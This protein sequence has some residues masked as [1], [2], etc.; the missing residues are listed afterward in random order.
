MLL[1]YSTIMSNQLLMITTNTIPYTDIRGYRHIGAF[2]YGA[3]LVMRNNTLKSVSGSPTEVSDE[4]T[5]TAAADPNGDNSPPQAGLP[6]VLKFDSGVTAKFPITPQD[7]TER[8][9]ANINGGQNQTS[10][11]SV[12]N[13]QQ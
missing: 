8:M 1:G 2:P 5:A 4:I 7:C 10:T 9:I 11:V 3:N 6:F 13:S 12:Q